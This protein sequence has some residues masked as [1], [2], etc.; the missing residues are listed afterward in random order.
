MPPLPEF[1]IQKNIY[2]STLAAS[3][4]ITLFLKF[5]KFQNFSSLKEQFF[6]EGK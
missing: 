6:C 1:I 4:Q 3:A 2:H 5:L